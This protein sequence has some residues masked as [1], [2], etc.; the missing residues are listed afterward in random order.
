MVWSPSCIILCTW[1][2]VKWAQSTYLTAKE[3]VKDPI[4]HLNHPFCV[5]FPLLQ[6]LLVH[7]KN[8]YTVQSLLKENGQY[9]LTPNKSSTIVMPCRMC[10][11]FAIVETTCFLRR[12]FFKGVLV[13]YRK[14]RRKLFVT[15]QIRSERVF[16]LA[17]LILNSHGRT[18]VC[19]ILVR[20]CPHIM[21]AN[22]GG[23]QTPLPPRQ[24]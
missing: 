16:F 24:Q 17:I 19:D 3:E 20:G 18:T 21:S 7:S 23:F 14:T 8:V 4:A 2:K 22:F 5:G 6:Y 15:L 10:L 13:S 11:I 12:K 1:P 9:F